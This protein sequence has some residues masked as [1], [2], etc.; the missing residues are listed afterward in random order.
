M[1]RRFWTP[2]EDAILRAA[3]EGGHGY[4]EAVH[5]LGAAGYVRTYSA[6]EQRSIDLRIGPVR[7]LRARALLLSGG[8]APVAPEPPRTDVP[9]L[10]TAD[11][12]EPDDEFLARVLRR[13]GRAVRKSAA[14]HVVRLTIASREP[15]ALSLSSDWHVTASGACDV[16]GLLDMARAVAATPG[17][18]ALGLGDMF[19]NPIKHKPSAVR[20]IPDDL[21]LLDTVVR[22]FRGKLLSVV[23]GN[24]DLWSVAV[25]GHDSLKAM[26]ERN[27]IHYVEDHCIWV[28]EIVDPDDAT[29]VTAR[30]VI[31]GRHKYRRHSS[32]NWTHATWRWLEEMVNDWP[33]DDDGRTLLPDVVALADNHVAEVATRAT[34]RGDVI[35]VRMGAWQVMSTYARG[36]GFPGSRP[37]APVVIL[38]PTRDERPMA[39]SDYALGLRTLTAMRR[40]A[41]AA[42]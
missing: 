28:V 37:T 1:A 15:I 32:L 26:M 33:Q 8:I 21:R 10:T 36:L 42:A 13:T 25:S 4:G 29:H 27:R 18:Y 2:A 3:V 7:S 12:P 17:A 11:E 38:P 6:C 23:A 19:D 40:G 5:R 20:D 22:E 14:A 35:A 16:A 31:A 34:P 39:F 41:D 24:H 30:W 9:V